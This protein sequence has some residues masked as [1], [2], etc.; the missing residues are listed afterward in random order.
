MSRLQIKSNQ[1]ARVLKLLEPRSSGAP[2]SPFSIRLGA[3]LRV[4][5][6]A[7]SGRLPSP[8]TETRDPAPIPPT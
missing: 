6:P 4:Q 8:R 3:W 2:R 1:E 5:A 7:D